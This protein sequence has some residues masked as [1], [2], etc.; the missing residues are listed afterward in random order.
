MEPHSSFENGPL[1]TKVCEI[2]AHSSFENGK[3][4]LAVCGAK[5]RKFV[6]LRRTPDLKLS[7]RAHAIE[8]KLRKDQ[9][10]LAEE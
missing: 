10:Y 1:S 3:R 4:V 6:K 2:E 9:S 5:P 7:F 8:D